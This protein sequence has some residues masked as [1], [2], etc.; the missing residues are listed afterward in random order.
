MYFADCHTHCICSPDSDVP[1]I[2]MAKAAYERGLKTLTLTDHCDLLGYD[3]GAR[4]FEYDWD[5]VMKER[6]MTLDAYGTKLDLPLGIEFGMGH[7]FP[8]VSEKILSQPGLDFV[9]GS[10]HNLDEEAGGL[11]FCLQN[12]DTLE[13]CYWALDNYF[14]SMLK[15]A[16]APYYDVVAH[17]IYPLRY[18][19]GNYPAPPSVER[20]HDQIK[21]I[22]RLAADSGR[23][24]EINTW[25]GQTL[26]EWI[27]ILKMY[28]EVRG[29]II[30][31]GSDA[32]APDPVGRGV[33]E[34]YT[35]MQDLGFRYQ[36]IYHERK[37]EMI[38]L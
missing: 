2:L 37:P 4:V 16:A 20:Y 27:P 24:I 38:R 33:K 7:L 30:T 14:S 36:A 11:D 13:N 3:D 17:I 15:M 29:E 21:E 6:A 28:K 10:C 12:Y 34:A 22:L 23:G 8:E 32:H 9:I 25:K 5:A 35:L 26:K 31:V 19:K 1:M 18:M